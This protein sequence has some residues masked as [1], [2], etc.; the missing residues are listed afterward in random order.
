MGCSRITRHGLP[1]WEGELRPCDPPP[2]PFFRVYSLHIAAPLGPRYHAYHNSHLGLPEV[3]EL[4][5]AAKALADIVVPLEYGITREVKVDIARKICHNLIPKVR[6][7]PL[8]ALALGTLSHTRVRASEPSRQP[9]AHA[10]ILVAG[11]NSIWGPDHANVRQEKMSAL[12][13]RSPLPD[14][15]APP[16]VRPSSLTPA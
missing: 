14:A 12:V 3:P 9:G 1:H 15:F 13:Q 11:S 8:P 7:G 5:W 6:L 16:M 4:F 10:A 2:P